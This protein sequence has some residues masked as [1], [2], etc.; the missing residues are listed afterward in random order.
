[1]SPA[2]ETFLHAGGEAGNAHRHD[3][4]LIG[5]LVEIEDA[6]L[7]R[8]DPVAE[9]VGRKLRQLRCRDVG[10]LVV[11]GTDLHE[12]KMRGDDGVGPRIHL[13]VRGTHRRSGGRRAPH[14]RNHDD[15]F[16]D[17][18]IH[19]VGIRH[20][21]QA[22]PGHHDQRPVGEA[23]AGGQV[24]DHVR[25]LGPVRGG[26]SDLTARRPGEGSSGAGPRVRDVAQPAGGGR[27][28]Q[29]SPAGHVGVEV[30]P[31]P[32]GVHDDAGQLRP[33]AVRQQDGVLTLPVVG[34]AVVGEQD[35]VALVDGEK[36]MRNARAE[37]P[38]LGAAQRQEGEP[39]RGRSGAVS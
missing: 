1:M 19:Q 6:R 12:A 11:V 27:R 2:A 10:G 38:A 18:R 37:V 3:G 25:A 23:Q 35:R 22:A 15:P 7:L 5:G 24:D 29:S 21:R 16:G 9:G 32:A 31:G 33:A 34:G 14:R 36:P 26:I 39:Q 17:R 28:H 30:G 8:R 13:A 4:D 20:V